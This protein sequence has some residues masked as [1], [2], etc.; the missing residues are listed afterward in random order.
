MQLE[1]SIW[2]S[3]ERLWCKSSWSPWLL[4]LVTSWA[5]D[6]LRAAQVAC[7]SDEISRDSG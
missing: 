2:W 4:G 1:E 6:S 5:C 7:E 3:M